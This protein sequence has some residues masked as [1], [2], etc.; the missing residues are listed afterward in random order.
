MSGRVQRKRSK[1]GV[2][3]RSSRAAGRSLGKRKAASHAKEHKRCVGAARATSRS[4]FERAIMRDLDD[5][6]VHYDYESRAFRIIVPVPRLK[7]QECG[8]KITRETRYTPDFQIAGYEVWIEAKGKLTPNDQRR[9]VAF[10]EQHVLNKPGVRYYLLF[11]RDNWLTK[12]KRKRYT[13][14][15]RDNGIRC[16]VGAEVPEE[17]LKWIPMKKA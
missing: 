9:I 13:D 5:R 3:L 16:A 7:C 14:W 10:N 2:S 12:T 6:G 11:M 15:A 1:D 4:G 8:A 17:W